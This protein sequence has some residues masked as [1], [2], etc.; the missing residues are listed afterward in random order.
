MSFDIVL[1]GIL[2]IILRILG[3]LFYIIGKEILR[4]FGIDIKKI[5]DYKVFSYK[6]I[7]KAESDPIFISNK[8]P[9]LIGFVFW[10]I[11]IILIVLIIHYC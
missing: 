9:I 6:K 3:Y 10:T 5:Q 1:Q 2:E 11:L 8:I 7:N 4:I